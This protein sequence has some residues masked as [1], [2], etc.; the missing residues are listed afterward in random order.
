M[1]LNIP[2]ELTYEFQNN[3]FKFT[4]RDLS[5]NWMSDTDSF[6][7]RIDKSNL[8]PVF[9]TRHLAKEIEIRNA[10]DE[11]IHF[12]ESKKYIKSIEKFDEVLFYDPGYGE[13]LLNKSFSL[14]RQRHFVKALRYY[15]KAVK[16]DTNLK[17]IEYQKNLLGEADNERDNFPKIKSNIYAGDEY[18]ANGEYRKAVDSYNRALKDSS[19]FKERILSKLL[20]KKATALLKLKEYEK[21]LDCSNDSLRAGKSDYAYFAQGL[22][23]HA[24]GLE[25]NDKFKAHLNITKKQM[26]RQVSVLNDLG[27]YDESLEISDY[28]CCNHFK[29]DEFYLKLL[30]A[31]K[32]TM[33]RL[34][35]DLS[36]I[37]QIIALVQHNLAG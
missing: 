23:Q 6:I 35:L 11:G 29:V 12:L 16:E 34:D 37:N 13:A 31:R 15:R 7:K 4:F 20:N 25:V 1:T 27:L 28:L 32:M 19:K 33:S 14:C 22:C 24:L 17:D 21:A 3:K 30:N 8:N 10:L 36:E 18:F 26:L 2:D 9:L 5:T